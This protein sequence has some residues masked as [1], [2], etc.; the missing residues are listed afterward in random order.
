MWHVH[1]VSFREMGKTLGWKSD[2]GEC[3]HKKNMVVEV[4]V[5]KFHGHRFSFELKTENEGMR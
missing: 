4:S 1:G 3:L 5:P 2:Q